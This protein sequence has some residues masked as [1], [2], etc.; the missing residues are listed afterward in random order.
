MKHQTRPPGVAGCKANQASGAARGVLPA[1]RSSA[2]AASPA[3]LVNVT[4]GQRH[5][6][7]T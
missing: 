5:D 6:D 4:G 1:V 7:E 2:L 3:R